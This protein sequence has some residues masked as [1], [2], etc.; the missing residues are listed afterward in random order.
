M[1]GKLSKSHQFPQPLRE[2]MVNQFDMRK[3]ILSTAK[4]QFLQFG[5]SKVTVDEIASKLGI[6]KKTIYKF[7][8][9]KDEIINILLTQSMTEMDAQCKSIVNREDLGFVDKLR[10]MMKNIAIQYSAM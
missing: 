5:F 2:I 4:S 6:S 3:H 10:E 1:G 9:S 7:F 8:S